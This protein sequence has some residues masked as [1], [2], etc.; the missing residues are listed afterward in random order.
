M[1][2][3]IHL[4]LEDRMIFHLSI[5]FPRRTLTLTLT[6]TPTLTPTLPPQCSSPES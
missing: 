4:G 3:P 1:L 2:I 6:L 5:L